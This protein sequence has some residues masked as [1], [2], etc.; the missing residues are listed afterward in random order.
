MI[1]SKDGEVILKLFKSKHFLLFLLT[2][3][4]LNI[5]AFFAVSHS[6][7]E[8]ITITKN[9]T[10]GSWIPEGISW[11][12]KSKPA[13]ISPAMENSS[14]KVSS[15]NK[16]NYS[17]KIYL[18]GFLPVKDVSISV[19][20]EMS[21]IPGGEAIGISLKTKGVLAVGIAPFETADGK[22]LSPGK[23]AGIK[24]GDVI[25]HIDGKKINKAGE[26]TDFISSSQKAI[27]LSGTRGKRNISWTVTPAEDKKDGKRKIGIWIRETV[28]GIGTVSFY[29]DSSF[30]ALGHSISDI[31]TGC[32]VMA[33][34]GNVY[35]AEIIGIDK[36]EEG[37][38][39]SL[40][41]IFSGSSI[42]K[43][44]SNSHCGVFGTATHL[45]D[46]APVKIA[47]KNEVR[48]GDAFIRCNLGGGARNYKAKILRIVSDADT[49]KNMIIEITDK[50]LLKK[51]G[52]IVQGMSGSP[53]IQNGKLVGAVTHVFVNDPTRGYGIFIENM[54]AEAEKIK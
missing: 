19:S 35:K 31:D 44:S 13:K 47:S 30:A 40:R 15:D 4:I 11:L 54:L 48:P 8:N 41:G 39:G 26:L 23:L 46:T 42:G 18:F 36:G 24:T 29:N 25:T 34:G 27:V 16:A 45:P 5:S 32:D 7:P 37:T 14:R 50:E 17:E 33:D 38:P 43:I 3:F 22:T 28:A 1:I 6:L 2:F 12:V 21:V 9:Q 20:E 49:A 52:G 53:V 10:S 51:T